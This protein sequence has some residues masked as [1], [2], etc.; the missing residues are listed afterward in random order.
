[1]IVIIVDVE[2]RNNLHVHS[3]IMSRNIKKLSGPKT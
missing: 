3:V 2:D 1:M